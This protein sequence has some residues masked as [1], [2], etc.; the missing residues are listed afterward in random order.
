MLKLLLSGASGTTGQAVAALVNTDD[1]FTLAG[2]ACRSRFF[3][4]DIDADVIVDF[5]HPELLG[6]TLD[7]AVQRRLPL[8]T[9]T[10]GTATEFERLLE[11]AADHIPICRAANFSV[12]VTLLCRLV[13]QAARVLG[14]EFDAEISEIHHRRKLDAPSGTALALGKAVARGR[15]Q[16][17][18]QIG[19]LDRSHERRPRQRGELGIQALRG[20]DVVGEHT[21]YFLGDAERLELTHRA[22]DRSLFARGALMAAARLPACEPGLIDFDRLLFPDPI[23]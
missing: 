16:S 9:G 6:R 13:E 2:E 21:V 15:G 23:I 14:Q 3:P 10:T 8:V 4:D 7:F 17:L 1:R 20:G 22:A 19:V 12:G 11:Q 18:D 5:S